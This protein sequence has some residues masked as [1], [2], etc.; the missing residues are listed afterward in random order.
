M[1][2]MLSFSKSLSASRNKYFI[3]LKPAEQSLFGYYERFGYKTVFTKKTAEINNDFQCTDEFSNNESIKKEI[4]KSRDNIFNSINYFKWDNKA[5]E[6]AIR[7]HEYFG[8]K[9]F[10]TPNGYVLY[11]IKDD[12]LFI[13][14]NT[15]SDETEFLKAINS[16]CK[17]NDANSV[18]IELPYNFKINCDKY[19]IS[20]SGMILPLNNKA[21]EMILSLNNAYL[22]LALD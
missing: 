13:K 12:I 15:I 8:G 4:I 7:H 3:I 21:E 22:N 10:K 5:V 20:D 2:D 14:E 6:F 16:L 11:Y 9:C 1:G 19:E 18:R 17:K